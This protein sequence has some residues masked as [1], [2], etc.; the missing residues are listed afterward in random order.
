MN[1]LIAYCLISCAFSTDVYAL[2]PASTERLDA[3]AERGSHVMPFSLEKTLHIFKPTDNGGIQQVIA[4]EAGGS[5]QIALIRQHLAGLSAQFVKGDFSGP[6][7]I[8]GNDMPGVKE[9]S[10]AAGQV[11]FAYQDLPDGGQIAFVSDEPG[12]IAAIH[13]YFTAQL[14]DHARHVQHH[15]HQP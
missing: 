1:K 15:G 13:A 2:E 10:T 11:H 4:K 12:L 5:A 14:S 3:V 8:H 9:L 6:Q 7:R